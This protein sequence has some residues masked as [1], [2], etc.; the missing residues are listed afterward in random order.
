MLHVVLYNYSPSN[1][2]VILQDPG[3]SLPEVY[4]P[5]QVNYF[6]LAKQLTIASKFCVCKMS[7]LLIFFLLVALLAFV[8]SEAAECVAKGHNCFVGKS[9]CCTAPDLNTVR[10][11]TAVA[12]V[13]AAGY[14]GGRKMKIP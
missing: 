5:P 3:D 4:K 8:S 1:H 11:P 14:T 2:L 12:A 6:I 7:K 10:M 13:T 9:T